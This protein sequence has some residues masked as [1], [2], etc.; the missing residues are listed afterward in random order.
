MESIVSCPW[1]PTCS[2]C[3]AIGTP[4][5]EQLAAKL[6]QVRRLFADARIPAFD[7]DRITKIHPSERVS[8]YRN[9][10]RLVPAYKSSQTEIN[11]DSPSPTGG[12]TARG[13]GIALGL[14]RED[15]HVVVDIP[16]C[17]VQ[18]AGI[19]RVLEDIRSGTLVFSEYQT[20]EIR[21]HVSGD[22][23]IATG[24]ITADAA[25][26]GRKVPGPFRFT[27]VY[28]R[29]DGVWKVWLFHNT[30]VRKPGPQG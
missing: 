25:R 22:I 28:V 23:A 9:R 30:M 3:S 7:A 5:K 24:L 10:V 1:F 27:R 6:K 16:Q 19:N 2:G 29:R 12:A 4:Y 11:R 8:G 18:A 15:S 13:D 14:Y 26:D 17:P 21:W 20:P